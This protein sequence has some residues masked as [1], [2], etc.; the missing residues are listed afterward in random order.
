MRRDFLFSIKL[1]RSSLKTECGTNQFLTRLA[2]RAVP[3]ALSSIMAAALT[4]SLWAANISPF[5]QD[6]NQVGEQAYQLQ[7]QADRLEAYVRSGAH[8]WVTSA[9]FASDMAREAQTLS[10]LLDKVAVR[11]GA[12]NDTRMQVRKMKDLTDEL[13][14]FTGNTLGDLD[15]HGM[16]LRLNGIF[17]NTANIEDRCDMIRSAAQVLANTH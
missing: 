1:L 6:L 15:S 11:P 10:S 13:T 7:T 16:A 8:D 9:S 14:A 12:T 4:G 3:F 17:A 5:A 2:V